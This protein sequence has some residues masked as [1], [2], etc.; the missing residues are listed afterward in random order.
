MQIEFILKNDQLL[1][2]DEI[3]LFDLNGHKLV[4]LRIK[5]NH[6]YNILSIKKVVYCGIENDQDVYRLTELPKIKWW[7]IEMIL[8]FQKNRDLIREFFQDKILINDKYKRRK[9][10]LIN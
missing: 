3:D 2:K 6:T 8:T 4:T 7:S 5:E 10:V 1:L 9:E